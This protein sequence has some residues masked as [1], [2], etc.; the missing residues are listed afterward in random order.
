MNFSKKNSI[1]SILLI[2]IGFSIGKYSS[3]RKSF[4]PRR[5]TKTNIIKN[6]IENIQ[7]KKSGIV[8][9]KSI[10][11]NLKDDCK[12]NNNITKNTEKI[13]KDEQP[14]DEYEHT[15]KYEKSIEEWDESLKVLFDENF[16][17]NNEL[18]EKYLVV[19][20]NFE[21]EN[22]IYWEKIKER[23]KVAENRYL[24]NTTYQETLERHNIAIKY[25]QKLEDSIGKAAY[26]LLQNK[27]KTYKLNQV[28]R[29][30]NGLYEG[31]YINF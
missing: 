24:F 13:K 17:T 8:K 20:E 7:E 16:Q 2:L 19:K 14:F 4:E 25:H 9:N 28:E 30:R 22:N 6:K 18:H 1:I 21:K 10:T 29:A 12:I 27:I 5:I 26:K 23:S 15:I 31:A 3:S 11:S